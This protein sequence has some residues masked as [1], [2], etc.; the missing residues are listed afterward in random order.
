MAG[1]RA[2]PLERSTVIKLASVLGLEDHAF[3]VGGQ[4]LNLWAERYAAGRP[5][6]IQFG[7][8]TSKDLD[9]YG[10]RAAAEKLAVAL[11][12]ELRVP[13]PDDHTP[14]SAVVSAEIDGRRVEIDFLTDVIGVKAN[15]LEREAVELV[16]PVRGEAVEELVIPI[17]HPLH[18]LQSRVGNIVGLG[19]GDDVALRQLAAAPIVVAAYIDEMLGL[20]DVKEATATLRG[21]F[22][23]LRSD[24][25]GRSCHEL[26]MRDPAE[27][28]ARFLTDGRL[29]RRFRWFNL[30]SMRRTLG[31]RRRAAARS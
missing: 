7:P 11:G 21:L 18:C 8:F 31:A 13:P 15:A 30:R 10:H 16:V 2:A 19:R 26:S 27:I 4:A 24:L 29:D 17:M 28:L 20:G 3:I 9:Y 14:N 22:E 12:G 23:Y 6:L 1:D 25:R 5:E